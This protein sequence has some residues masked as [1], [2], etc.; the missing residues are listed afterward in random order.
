MAPCAPAL[1]IDPELQGRV[2]LGVMACD[3]LYVQAE[4]AA[5]DARVAEAARALRARHAGLSSG[6]VPGVADA[7]ELYKSLGIDPTKT[8][9]SN[10]ALLRRVLRGA[11]L[12]RVNTLVDTVNLCSLT[13]QMPYG[14]YDLDR[15]VMPV[16]LRMGAA[17]ES[18][19][20]IRKGRVDVARRPVLADT[21]GAFGNPTSDSA[22]TMITEQTRAALV[23]LYARRSQAVARVNLLLDE[24]A[25]TIA[26][27][28]GGC[29][30]WRALI[31]ED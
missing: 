22:R 15:I 30:A 20:G 31:P 2:R 24:T 7:R 17:E 5:L 27:V 14:L 16:I 6:Q 4:E 23:V 25:R 8:R 9:P 11:E 28:C 29:V 21:Q 3:G 10:E 12:Y 18:Y 19:E 13:Q 1:S 26:G